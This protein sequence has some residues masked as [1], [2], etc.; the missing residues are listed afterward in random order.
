MAIYIYYVKAIIQHLM[1]SII[2]YHT[3]AAFGETLLML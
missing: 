3:K 2:T 1:N